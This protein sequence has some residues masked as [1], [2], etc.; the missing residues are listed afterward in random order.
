[1]SEWLTGTAERSRMAADAV[2]D[3]WVKG[4][5]P[6]GRLA[7]HVFLSMDGASL[8]F[9]AKW[10]SHDD[11]LAWARARRAGVVS[12]VDTLVPGIERPGLT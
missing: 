11:H 12:R 6:S 7:Q 10:T 3:E 1:M 9:H 8:F 4:E 5:T 2:L